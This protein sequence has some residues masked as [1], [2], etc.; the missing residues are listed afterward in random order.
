MTIYYGDK[1]I[2]TL[3]CLDQ[4]QWYS[5][6]NDLCTAETNA[7]EAV[8]QGMQEIGLSEHQMALQWRIHMAIRHKKMFDSG[9]GTL[10]VSG[11]WPNNPQRSSRRPPPH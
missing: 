4:F 9:I 5:P 2:T 6:R 11:E 3:V 10:G 8:F 7:I 1:L